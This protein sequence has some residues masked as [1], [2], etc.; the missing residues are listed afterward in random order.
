MKSLKV[1]VPVPEKVRIVVPVMVVFTAEVND[2]DVILKL[3]VPLFTMLP[4]VA[5]VCVPVT[6]GALNAS[7][8]APALTV[9]VPATVSVT[10]VALF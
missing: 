6:V 7:K 4:V 1:V 8:I 10:D 3:M 2:P 9:V 5:N